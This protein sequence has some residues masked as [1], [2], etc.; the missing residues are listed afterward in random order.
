MPVVRYNGGIASLK[1]RQM[2]I[3]RLWLVLVIAAGV[4]HLLAVPSHADEDERIRELAASQTWEELRAEFGPRYEAVVRGPLG[5]RT[6]PVRASEPSGQRAYLSRLLCPETGEPPGGPPR[7]GSTGGGPYPSLLDMYE[8]DCGGESQTVFID[9]YH[10]HVEERPLPGFRIVSS[11]APTLERDEQGVYY[12]RESGDVA[13]G[14]YQIEDSEGRV[15]RRLNVEEGRL[16]GVFEVLDEK[17]TRRTRQELLD[18]DRN[19]VA[20]WYDAEGRPTVQAVFADCELHGPVLWFTEDGEVRRQ[21]WYYR[22]IAVGEW[23]EYGLASDESE[24]R[25]GFI[26]PEADDDA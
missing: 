23:T 14:L 20:T 10:S 4:A 26:K 7:L 6:N 5:S 18:G 8:I 24:W 11:M 9:M 25:D 22:G 1:G 3:Q 19:G 15:R 12:E 2:A 17:G 13:D 21:G 16:A